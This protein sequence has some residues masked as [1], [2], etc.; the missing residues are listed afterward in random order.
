MNL[1]VQLLTPVISHTQ[2]IAPTTIWCES[3]NKWSDLTVTHILRVYDEL[4]IRTRAV[5]WL[6]RRASYV[7]NVAAKFD[8]E[9]EPGQV[10]PRPAAERRAATSW[11]LQAKCSNP[12]AELGHYVFLLAIK[13]DIECRIAKR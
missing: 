8:K 12:A 6:T 5:H 9:V 4:D 2:S 10:F 7:V 3:D 13:P 1:A 11:I